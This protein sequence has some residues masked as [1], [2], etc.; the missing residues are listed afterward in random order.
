M[1]YETFVS[2]VIVKLKDHSTIVSVAGAVISALLLGRW[3][4]EAGGVG[5]AIAFTI[6]GFAYGGTFA[7]QL[8]DAVLTAFG[9]FKRVVI[10]LGL[11]GAC[12]VVKILFSSLSFGLLLF[13]ISCLYL[14]CVS[15]RSI[16]QK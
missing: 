16:S 5:G 3:G 13:I 7:L 10:F 15:R 2:K 8:P 11:L 1:G 6:M 4:Y 12:V 14:V 9:T